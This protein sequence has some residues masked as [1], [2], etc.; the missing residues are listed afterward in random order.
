MAK[1]DDTKGAIKSHMDH[2]MGS[3]KQGEAKVQAE[4]PHKLTKD[5]ISNVQP[6][7]PKR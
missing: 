5:E 4:Y 6:R 1:K 7:P 2:P 3:T